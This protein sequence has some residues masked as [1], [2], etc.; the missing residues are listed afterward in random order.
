MEKYGLLS[1]V[2]AIEA[3]LTGCAGNS[4][5]VKPAAPASRSAEDPALAAVCKPIQRVNITAVTPGSPSTITVDLAN[6][7]IESGSGLVIWKFKNV[8]GYVFVKDS[9]QLK[10]ADQPPGLIAGVASNN[11]AKYFAIFDNDSDATWAYNLKFTSADGTQT[12][13][14]DPTITNRGN[15]FAAAVGESTISCIVSVGS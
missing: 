2:L 13:I 14:C 12:W 3:L 10:L 4:S 8:N 15:V 5:V 6:A 7:C 9:V 1:L 11:K